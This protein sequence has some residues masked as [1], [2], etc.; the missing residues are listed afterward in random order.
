MR[1]RHGRRKYRRNPVTG[2]AKVRWNP[3]G[4]TGKILIA[5][6]ATA[7]VAGGIGAILYFKKAPAVTTSLP[8]GGQQ[9]DAATKAAAD[10][11]TARAAADAAAAAVSAAAKKDLYQR[12]QNAA[13]AKFT[14]LWP[15]GEWNAAQMAIGSVQA[16]GVPPAD[17]LNIV[18]NAIV[19]YWMSTKPTPTLT[20]AQSTATGTLAGAGF[21]GVYGGSNIGTA[22][23][24]V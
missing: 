21:P 1:K 23:G 10:A 2:T 6:A 16:L 17:V 15:S 7:I 4:D 14:E 5:I 3:T 22:Q 24:R 20:Q 9:Q 13:Q 19:A 12:A 8:A 18:W 11:A